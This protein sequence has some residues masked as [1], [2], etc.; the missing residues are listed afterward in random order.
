MY[1]HA[2]HEFL[3]CDTVAS[4]NF[5]KA[6]LPYL[7]PLV[8]NLT[9]LLYKRDLFVSTSLLFCEAVQ[10]HGLLNFMVY[11][12]SLFKGFGNPSTN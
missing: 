11:G 6:I 9:N 10:L 4:S 8:S 5:A 7:M 12:Q 3:Y 1:C 2:V